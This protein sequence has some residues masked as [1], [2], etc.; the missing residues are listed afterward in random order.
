[1]IKFLIG[2]V[3]GCAATF[4]SLPWIEKQ[5][6]VLPRPAIKI[7]IDQSDAKYRSFQKLPLDKKIQLVRQQA[8]HL[9]NSAVAGRELTAT[10]FE[11]KSS[12]PRIEAVIDEV[13][14]DGLTNEEALSIITLH[15][16]SQQQQYTIGLHHEA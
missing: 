3:L 11:I 1:M 10:V 6:G 13:T 5:F 12:S 14:R 8:R 4:Y 2:F 7:G 15:L 16:R 9:D